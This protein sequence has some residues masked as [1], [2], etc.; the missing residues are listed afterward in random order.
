MA[1]QSDASVA[2]LEH[3]TFSTRIGAVAVNPPRATP[4]AT[5]KI[6]TIASVDEIS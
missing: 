2:L 1:V 3:V 4:P 6:I 5:T